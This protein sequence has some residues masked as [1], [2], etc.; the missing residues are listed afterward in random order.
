MINLSQPQ[1][2]N[3]AHFTTGMPNMNV[4]Q[5]AS[6]TS[7]PQVPLYPS[8]MGYPANQTQAAMLALQQ[9]QQQLLQQKLL[10]E[11]Q[12]RLAGLRNLQ[13]QNNQSQMNQLGMSNNISYN[14]QRQPEVKQPEPVMK[15]PDDYM[16]IDLLGSG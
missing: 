7:H 2:P 9:R 6:M 3:Q 11:Q 13:N 15:T 14:P 12:Q 1:V 8:Q 5:F 16:N 4:H 10:L